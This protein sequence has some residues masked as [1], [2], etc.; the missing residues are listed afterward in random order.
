MSMFDGEQKK[1]ISSKIK[2]IELFAG[3]G[4]QSLAM[5]YLGANYE[6]H[7]ICE[8]AVK[9]IQAYKDLHFANDNTDYSKDLSRAEIEQFL[10]DRG[11]SIDYSNPATIEQI[12][13]LGEAQCR[14][15]YNNII[16]THNLVSV[17]NVKGEDLEIKDTDKYEYVVSYSFPC[18][19]LSKAGNMGGMEKGSGT[20]SG[21]LWEV[22]RILCEIKE[23][24]LELPQTLLME[25]VPDVISERNR[26]HFN[27]WLNKLEELGYHNYYKI[28]NTKDMGLPQN[29]ARCFMVSVLGNYYVD[30]PPRKVKLKH[31]LKD[32]LEKNV[33]E[34]Y[35]LS[36]KMINYLTGVNQKDSNFPRGE[37]FVESLKT[38]NEK[39]FATTVTTNAGNRPVDNFIVDDVKDVEEYIKNKGVRETLAQNNLDEVEDI[40]FLDASNNDFLLIRNNTQQGFLKAEE[41]DGVDISTRMHFHRGTVQKGKSQ[42]LTCAGGEN[43]GVVVGT[44]NYGKS[45]NFMQGKD[46]FKEGK[47]IA[48]C[49]LTTQKEGVVEMVEMPNLKTQLCNQL[50]EQGRVEGN[51]VI[52][53]NYTTSKDGD[54]I[55][56]NNISPTLDTRCDCLGIVAAAQRGREKGQ[57]LEISNRE[58]ANA[59]TT[60]QKDSMIAEVKKIGNYSPSGHNAASIVDNKGCAPTVME[61]HGTVTATNVGLRIRKLTPREAF[62]LQGVA[63]KDIDK[64]S[65]YANNNQ[66]HLAGD[67]ISTTVLMGIFGELL[68]VDYVKIIEDFI[69][70]NIIEK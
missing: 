57:Q 34:K 51:D 53:H 5:N 29:R 48:D 39:D 62:R 37:R 12:K 20:R 56:S 33:D 3:Y 14:T 31:K 32:L 44:Y 38:T 17:C 9:S 41:G 52:R 42:T 23:K 49:V 35:Y 63:N 6:H 18:Q 27:S 40:A 54:C 69:E 22:E 47:E 68:D 36:N 24:G 65:H 1:V 67:S 58:I 30:M 8:W 21:L 11:I 45:E 55:Q 25:N 4:S 7:K 26:E 16:A 10:F 60:V 43:V 66:F 50:I 46:R 28:I 64:M 13:R 70:N 61:N 2:M 19:D 15:I 59:L